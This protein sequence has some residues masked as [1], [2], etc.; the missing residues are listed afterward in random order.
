MVTTVLWGYKYSCKMFS[1]H[2]RRVGLGLEV[3]KLGCFQIAK[4]WSAFSAGPFKKQLLCFQRTGV[5]PKA[6]GEFYLVL[7]YG[8][9][10]KHLGL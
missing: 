1:I 9:I 8:S 10:F 7:R 4:A 5:G 3:Q 2:E 6:V